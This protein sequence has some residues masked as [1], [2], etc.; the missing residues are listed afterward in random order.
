MFRGFR[1]RSEAGY[2]LAKALS[3]YENRKNTLILALPRGGVP[4]AFEV[5]NILNLPMDIWLVR[6]L[7]VPG[8]EEL[9][10]GA[11]ALN[12][13]CHMNRDIARGMNITERLL[14]QVVTREKQELTRRNERYRQGSELPVV[15]GKTIIIIDDG[16][17]TGAT[18]MAAIQS[19][20]HA[21]AGLIVVAVPVGSA[22]AYR[23]VEQ[24]ADEFYCLQ[25]PEPFFGVG[26]WYMDFSQLSDQDVLDIMERYRE[27]RGQSSDSQ[28]KQRA[29]P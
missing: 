13:A 25:V 2:E 5:A 24:T 15:K 8:H 3:V 21:K 16:L 9:A 22:E 1:D 19:L 17:A 14:N 28:P 10:M 6:K 12:G 7:G 20:R 11:I 23:A 27:L 26:Q 18:M 4:V 29:A